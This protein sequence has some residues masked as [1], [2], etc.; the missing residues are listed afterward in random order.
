VRTKK[1]IEITVE[2]NQLLVIRRRVRSV[3]SRCATCAA[4]VQMV[5]PEEA[6]AV[7]RVGMHTIYR[8]VEEGR[9]HITETGDGLLWICLNSLLR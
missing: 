9:L 7:A 8:W 1:R 4:V 2:A 6:V 5:T 3:G